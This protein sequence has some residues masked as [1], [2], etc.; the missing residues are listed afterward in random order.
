MGEQSREEEDLASEKASTKDDALNEGEIL[1]RLLGILGQCPSQSMPLVEI[2]EKMPGQ[3]RNRADD[4]VCRWLQGFPGVLEVSGPKGQETVMLTV[5]KLGP[6]PGGPG[7][8]GVAAPSPGPTAGP[9]QAAVSTGPALPGPVPT[10]SADEKPEKNNVVGDE[11]SSNPSSVQLRGLPFRAT[12]EDVQ[13]FLGEHAQNLSSEKNPNICLLSN[14]D[15]RPSGFARVFF[16][17]PQAA[18]KCRDSLHKKQM[19]ER[20][21]EV[22]AYD[23]HGK[24]RKKEESAREQQISAPLDAATE[25]AERQRVLKECRGHMSVRGQQQILLSMLGIALSEEARAYLRRAN[26]GLKHFLACFPHEFRVEGPKGMEA[27]CWLS[28]EDMTWTMTIPENVPST[29]D[30]RLMSPG[31]K[32]PPS[33]FISTPSVWA[34]PQAP[35]MHMDFMASWS[36][37]SSYGFPQFPTWPTWEGPSRPLKKPKP[38]DAPVSRSHAH[39]H[40]QSHPFANRE[41][42]E[43]SD[44]TGVAALRLRGLPFSVTVQDVLTFFAQHNVA[45]T[46]YDGPH[47]AQL[48]PKANGRPSGQAVV[49]M[50]SRKDA[51]TAQ[52][53]L[54]HQ[55]VGGRYIEVFVYGDSEGMIENDI[56]AWPSSYAS[57]APWALSWP[58]EEKE[59]WDALMQTMPAMPAMPAMPMPGMPGMPAMPNFPFPAPYTA[60][61]STRQTL[62]V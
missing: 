32:S 22:L 41:D 42:E 2:L 29:P 14:R 17:S 51:E 25:Q 62:Q 36:S 16:V 11:D 58:T 15:G 5:G 7:L 18:H 37:M 20:Y 60:E 52:K 21:I 55:Y 56:E 13:R 59:G 61:G 46:I 38:T 54:N 50:R 34:S 57:S 30:A 47:S 28:A 3:L 49:Q 35:P 44:K 43:E 6:G 27:V 26:L 9:G 45:D 53:A 1:A 10:G 48:L 39:L 8:A 31:A 23:R 33:Q 4:S 19:G 40:P 24:N 12:I